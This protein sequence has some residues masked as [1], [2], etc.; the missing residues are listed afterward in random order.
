[1]DG[2]I[3]GFPPYGFSAVVKFGGSIMRDLAVCK[4]AVAELERLADHGHKILVVPGGGIPDKAIEAVDV[5]ASLTPSTAHHACALAQDQTGYM[6]ADPAFSSKLVPSASLGECR[7]LAKEAK[8]PV[9][10]PSRLLFAA[11]PVEWTWHI[12]SDAVAAWIAWLTSTPRLV[13]WT[14]VDGVYRGGAVDDPAA[15]V[16]QITARELVRFGHTSIDACA[17]DFMA[18]KHLPGAVINARYPARLADW[19]A[20]TPVRAT[21]I[22]VNGSEEA[23]INP[24]TLGDT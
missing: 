14:N 10:L 2:A 21:D 20:G 12:T 8:V 17:V 18:Q 3:N 13:I 19:L 7:A 6:L 4:H 23:D 11:D 24:Q 22:T 1:M 9:L 16:E 5:A 15:L